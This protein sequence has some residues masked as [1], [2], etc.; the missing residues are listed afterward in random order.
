MQKA[1]KDIFNFIPVQFVT[2][3]HAASG[4][5]HTLVL[6]RQKSN[7]RQRV[8]VSGVDGIF[9]RGEMSNLFLRGRS[10]AALCFEIRGVK[11]MLQPQRKQLGKGQLS[12]PVGKSTDTLTHTHSLIWDTQKKGR[13][14][15]ILYR[16]LQT[17]VYHRFNQIRNGK[18]AEICTTVSK[19]LQSQNVTLNTCIFSS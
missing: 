3:Q 9:Q 13:I 15:D 7:E 5:G 18:D 11:V 16:H 2:A 17:T 19:E 14:L 1:H 10:A 12:L 6:K 4:S 8:E